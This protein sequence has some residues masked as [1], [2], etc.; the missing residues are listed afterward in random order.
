MSGLLHLGAEIHVTDKTSLCWSQHIRRK[1]TL[2]WSLSIL[3]VAFLQEFHNTARKGPKMLGLKNPDTPLAIIFRQL[4]QIFKSSTNHLQ[5]PKVHQSL[6]A[7]DG[8]ASLAL[9]TSKHYLV[10]TK[11]I[12]IQLVPPLSNFLQYEETKAFFTF[13]GCYFTL[14]HLCSIAVCCLGKRLRNFL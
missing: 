3:C 14:S 11:E 12:R 2:A 5:L 7:W 13:T 4:C 6:P 10:K 1:C 9:S 8:Y